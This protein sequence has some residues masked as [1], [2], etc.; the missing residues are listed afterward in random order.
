MLNVKQESCEYQL[1]KG[2]W[3]DCNIERFCLHVFRQM[4]Y[5]NGYTARLLRWEILYELAL[6]VCLHDQ[7][8]SGFFGGPAFIQPIR[9]I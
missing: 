5:Q 1:F 4:G 7:N 8:K 2:F 9:A 3:S 6:L